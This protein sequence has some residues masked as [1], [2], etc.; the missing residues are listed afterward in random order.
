[1]ALDG[2]KTGHDMFLYYNAG[3]YATPT[4]TVIDEIGDVSISEFTRAVAELR[5]RASEFAK[6]LAG[7]FD[8]INVEFELRHGLTEAVFEALRAAFFAGTNM[9]FQIMSGDITSADA[10]GLRAY[11]IISQFPWEQPL[12]DVS[13]HSVRLTLAYQNDSSDVEID[14]SWVAYTGGTLE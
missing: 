5:R 12:D 4:W 13:N 7:T 1:M 14:P 2:P 6:G 11:F 10:E 8:P 3:S 9:E